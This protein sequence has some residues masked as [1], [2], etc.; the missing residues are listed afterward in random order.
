MRNLGLVALVAAAVPISGCGPTCQ[1]T[2]NRLYQ[3]AE[4][5]CNIQSVASDRTELL[6][7]CNESCEDALDTPGE[8]G[9]YTPH[10]YTPSS[11]NIDLENDKQAAL[12]MD[13]VAETSCEHLNDGYCAPVW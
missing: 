3:E 13:C 1:S 9:D 10:E 8:I 5:S 6:T 4:P 7:R 12:W 2:C 11:K